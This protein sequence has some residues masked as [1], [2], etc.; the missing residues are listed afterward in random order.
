MCIDGTHGQFIIVNNKCGACNPEGMVLLYASGL[1]CLLIKIL[2]FRFYVSNQ[3]GVF[4]NHVL[5]G[6]GDRPASKD[7]EKRPA[8]DSQNLCRKE[9]MAA[10][11]ELPGIAGLEQWVGRISGVQWP[12]GVD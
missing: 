7:G 8:F 11:L 1:F 3:N 2:L 9:R 5:W 10:C 12:A 6:L 4:K